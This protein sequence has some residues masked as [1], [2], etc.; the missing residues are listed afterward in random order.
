MDGILH[1]LEYAYGL[2]K[3]QHRHGGIGNVSFQG[4][5]T[6]SHLDDSI[7]FSKV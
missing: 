6:D 2:G 7:R 1:E 5:R 3:I 4:Y